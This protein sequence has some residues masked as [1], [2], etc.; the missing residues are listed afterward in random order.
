[1]NKIAEQ[2]APIMN[3]EELTTLIDAHYQ[4]QA[5]TLTS[6]AQANLLKLK[7]THRNT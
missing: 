1:M 6:G 5:Q 3:D 2:I 4:N 7:E